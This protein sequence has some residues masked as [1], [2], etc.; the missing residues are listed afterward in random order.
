MIV[1]PMATQRC[2]NPACNHFTMSFAKP[3]LIYVLC[4]DHEYPGHRDVTK[5]NEVLIIF[6]VTSTQQFSISMSSSL[7][8]LPPSLL[9]RT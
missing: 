2:G 4:L 1:I 6:I 5:N 3:S 9:N 8:S 7:S